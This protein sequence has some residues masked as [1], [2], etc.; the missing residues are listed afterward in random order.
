MKNYEQEI[1]NKL[2]K[3]YEHSKLSKEGSTRNLKICLP[4]DSKNMPDYVG[5]NSYKYEENI[6]NTIRQL[7]D[8]N[9]ITIE[10]DKTNQY[11]KK[12][13]LNIEN[14]E[15]IYYFIEAKS[16]Q[17]I[18]NEY[19]VILSEFTSGNGLA[20]KFSKWA[21]NR[22]KEFKSLEKYFSNVEELQ[23]ILLVLQKL[24]EQKEEIS[25][26]T[27]SVK[28]LRDSKRLETILSKIESI[29]KMC[30]DIDDEDV[31]QR[32]NVF[33]NPSFIYLKGKGVFKINDQLIDLQNLNAELILSNYHLESMQI[34]DMHCKEVVTIENLT[35]F[36]DYPD[37]NQCVIYLGG[38]HNKIKRDILR[39]IYEYNPNINFYHSGDIDIGGFYILNH[40]IEDTKIK[41][42]PR[43]MDIATLEKYKENTIPLTKEDKRRIV[44][45]KQEKELEPYLDVLEYM[46]KNNVKLEQ[47]NIQYI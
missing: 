21:I 36:Y 29:I 16:P 45:L 30:E 10:Y 19:H 46:M 2:L 33:R 13:Y 39:K 31:L 26:R 23:E 8:K 6:E 15:E 4:F 34:I 9:F 11:V 20:S 41:F 40:L 37:L 47:E 5:E 18:R 43:M 35:S 38:F 42:K 3:K 1:L 24:E 17:I 12:V 22:L 7:A 44:L 14:I 27:F 32:F 28:Y 25:L